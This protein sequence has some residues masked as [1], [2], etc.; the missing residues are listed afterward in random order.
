VSDG[1]TDFGD[2]FAFHAHFAG[3]QHSP[4]LNIKQACGVKHNGR[5]GSAGLGWGATYE[6]EKARGQYQE[7]NEALGHGLAR[8]Y[9]F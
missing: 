3:R 5:R 7:G 1:G 2:P 4:G 9:H 6:R 8:W